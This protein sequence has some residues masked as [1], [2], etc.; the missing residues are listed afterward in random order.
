MRKSLFFNKLSNIRQTIQALLIGDWLTILISL[1]VITY[2][3]QTQW[4]NAPATKVQIR[5]GQKVY[6]IYSLNQQRDIKV[7]GKIGETT[8]QIGQGKARFLHAPCHNQYCVQQAWLTRAGQVA[9][10]LPNQ[11]TLALLGDQPL[12][13]SLNY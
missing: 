11:V 4:S 6:A 3:F 1:C 2:L 12:Y 13:D 10:C 8:I 5:V 7:V 9:I